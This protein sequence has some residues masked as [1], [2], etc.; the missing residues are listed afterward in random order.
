MITTNQNNL[1]F[2]DRLVG[3]SVFSK[4]QNSW[5]SPA[6]PSSDEDLSTW[7]NQ[8]KWYEK[9]EELQY[10]DTSK[11]YFWSDSSKLRIS[12]T[13]FNL[14]NST[15]ILSFLDIRHWFSNLNTNVDNSYTNNDGIYDV[16]EAVAEI[17]LE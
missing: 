10:T 13:N 16:T 5:I 7:G 14:D 8:L 1:T 4:A 12:E 9:F 3:M 15:K 11:P 17:G 6:A 2:T